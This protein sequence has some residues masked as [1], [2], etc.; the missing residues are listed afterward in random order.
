MTYKRV[1]FDGGQS[2]RGT[3]LSVE[4]LEAQGHEVQV[5]YL[6]AMQWKSQVDRAD[7]PHLPPDTRLKVAYA[8]AEATASNRLTDDVK[9]EQEKLLWAD[10]VIF[11][12]PM[13]WMGRPAILKGWFDRVYSLGFAYGLGEYNDSRWGDRY[14][15]GKI[16]GKKAFLVVTAGSWREHFSARGIS[17]PIDDL[18]FPINHGLLDYTGFEVLPQFMAY[19]LD[20]ADDL[21]FR[22]VV[23]ELRQRLRTIS[24]TRPIGYRRQNG[25]DY[26]IPTLTLKPELGAASGSG[27]SLHSV[28]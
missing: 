8:S 17:G 3:E 26:E 1:D 9:R 28:E 23:D 11:Q 15:E 12:F 25:G 7:F 18:L 14:V 2:M 4:E 19:Q 16:Q 21:V 5:S 22:S 10:T 6:Y 24:T 13:W 20:R 27:F